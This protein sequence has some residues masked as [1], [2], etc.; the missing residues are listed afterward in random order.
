MR[1]SKPLCGR[2]SADSAL[3]PSWRIVRLRCGRY[4]LE[5]DGLPASEPRPSRA[6]VIDDARRRFPGAG[7]P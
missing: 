2:D 4:R 5:I 1:A 7:I 3:P 6:D